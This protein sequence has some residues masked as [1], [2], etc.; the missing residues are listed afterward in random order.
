MITVLDQYEVEYK[1]TYTSGTYDQVVM[2]KMLTEEKDRYSN[3]VLKPGNRGVVYGLINSNQAPTPGST[4]FDSYDSTSYSLQ[5]YKEKAGNCRAAKHICFDERIFDT[6][7]PNPLACFKQNGADIFS[8]FRNDGPGGGS[9]NGINY[10]KNAIIMLDGYVTSGS[11]VGS[12]LNVGIDRHWT[13]SYPFEPRYSQVQRLKTIYFNNLEVLNVLNFTTPNASTTNRTRVKKA[14][15]YVGFF[16]TSKVN[17]HELNAITVSNATWYHYVFS[18]CSTKSGTFETGS[19]GNQD[20]IKVLFGFGDAKSVFFDRQIQD[21]NSPTGF[22]SRGTNNLVEFRE[23]KIPKLAIGYQAITGSFFV[24]G[25]VIRGWKYGLHSGLAD[26]SSAYYRQGRYGQYR[27]ML[28]QRLYTKFLY[29]D[30]TKTIV[31]ENDTNDAPVTVKFFDKNNVR[32]PP[33][34]TLSQNLSEYATS[35]L[36]YFDLEQRNVD[37]ITQGSSTSNLTLISISVDGDG[38]V[39]I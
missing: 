26:Y 3:K 14:G 28:E 18:D 8:P 13:K 25:P 22:L 27:D 4:I 37:P 1:E 35:S 19:A 32:T 30:V 6:L 24:I 5:P 21:S 29:D 2:G 12:Y 20:L 7:V 31:S 36:P 11:N 34:N 10:V 23:K 17:R 39:T 15:L 38:N 16:G 33:E 9:P